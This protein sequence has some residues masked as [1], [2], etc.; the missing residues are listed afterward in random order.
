MI[1]KSYVFLKKDRAFQKETSYVDQIKRTS[2]TLKLA[3][4]II[5]NVI[6]NYFLVTGIDRKNEKNAFPLIGKNKIIKTIQL[7]S[8]L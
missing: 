3:D 8:R 4:A 6:P 5:T 2:L 1:I 7:L